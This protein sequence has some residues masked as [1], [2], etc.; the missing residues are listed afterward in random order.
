MKKRNLVS[1]AFFLCLLSVPSLCFAQRQWVEYTLTKCIYADGTIAKSS[2][3]TTHSF[4]FEGDYV[5]EK[6]PYYGYTDSRYKFHHMEGTSAVYY[7]N[8]YVALEGYSKDFYYGV[9]LVVSQDKR[10]IN[11][12]DN[13]DD[14]EH[15]TTTVFKQGVDRTIG[16]MYE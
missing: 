7:R 6:Y 2:K 16:E 10:T 4:A 11:I 5:Y 3:T 12:V 14:S 9:A 8:L 13:A 15:K 1:M